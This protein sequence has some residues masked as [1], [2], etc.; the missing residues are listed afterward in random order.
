MPVF[1]FKKS[2]YQYDIDDRNHLEHSRLAKDMQKF[3]T[4]RVRDLVGSR[5]ED[6]YYNL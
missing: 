3:E 4:S 6:S 1:S 5:I 2:P